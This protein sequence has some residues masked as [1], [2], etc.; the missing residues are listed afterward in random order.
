MKQGVRHCWGN[1]YVYKIKILPFIYDIC[2]CIIY[3][4]I[5]I[6]VCVCDVA[7]RVKKEEN[8]PTNPPTKYI[9]LGH[10]M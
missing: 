4:Y 5:Y 1:Q 9:T 6:C 2:V 10:N 3:I 7:A 8:P